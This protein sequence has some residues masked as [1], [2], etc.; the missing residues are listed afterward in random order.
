MTVALAMGLD[1]LTG[2]II[3]GLAEAGLDRALSVICT[4]TDELVT[5]EIAL[6]VREARP[7]VR[8]VVQLANPSVGRALGRVTGPGSVLDVAALAAPSFVEVCLRHPIHELE[9]DDERFAVAQVTV[10]DD[11][12]SHRTFRGHFGNLA[13]VAIMPGDGS[14]MACCPGRD[15]PVSAGDRVAVLGLGGGVARGG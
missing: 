12:G 1:N 10:A 8:M 4:E 6:R 11:E 2:L 14:P 13:P 5:L 3:A 9:I 15:H 7:D